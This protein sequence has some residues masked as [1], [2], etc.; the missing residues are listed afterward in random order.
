MGPYDPQTKQAWEKL[1]QRFGKCPS[2]GTEAFENYAAL[3]SYSSPV[4]ALVGVIGALSTG[5]ILTVSAGA[6]GILDF[7]EYLKN[8]YH[9]N[10]SGLGRISTAVI[11]GNSDLS[12]VQIKG[13]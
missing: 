10:N 4:R 11:Q 9:T 7:G 12:N 2:C 8:A 1:K 5:D 3:K 6:D 13:G